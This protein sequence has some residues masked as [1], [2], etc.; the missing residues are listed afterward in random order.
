MYTCAR[1][2]TQSVTSNGNV[3]ET[4]PKITGT[5]E[6]TKT[7]QKMSSNNQPLS[8]DQPPVV[9]VQKRVGES[10]SK[11]NRMAKPTKGLVSVHV[12]F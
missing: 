9:M 7:E 1:T 10:L 4:A 6:P 3:T 12:K 11:E 2:N 8:E 5:V